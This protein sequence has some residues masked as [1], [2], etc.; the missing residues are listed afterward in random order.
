MVTS[1]EPVAPS[2]PPPTNSPGPWICSHNAY[3][4]SDFSTQSEAQAAFESCGGTANDVHQLDRDRDG[5][6]CESLP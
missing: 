5:Q 4:C 1:S 6:V 3:N 2:P